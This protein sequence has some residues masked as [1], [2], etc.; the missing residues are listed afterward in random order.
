[1][2]L[3]AQAATLESR[4]PFLHFFDGFR[5]S[6]EVNKIEQLTTTTTAR[7]DRRRGPVRGPPRARPEP[8]PPGAA[9]H[10]PEPGRLLPGARDVNPFYDEG[11]RHRAG[12]MDR[13]A[14]LTG[15]RTTC[16]T[17][18]APPTP[19]ASSCSWAPAPRRRGDVDHLAPRARRSACLKV[20][21]YR[22]FDAEALPRG[23]AGETCKSS[24]ARPHQGAGAGG[25][26]LYKDVVTRL[27]RGGR[28]RGRRDRSRCRGHRRPLRPVVEGVHPGDGQG[29]SSTSSPRTRRRT[30]SPS[31]STTT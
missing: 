11:A 24:R 18:S 30:A 1:M 14:E 2:A 8:G 20:R 25:E 16:S 7:D 29:V 13:F 10:R 21:L 22:P 6:H 4:V 3:I 31:A 15:R 19:S 12:G 23:P 9:R 26:P 27:A 28:R 5:T 17:T